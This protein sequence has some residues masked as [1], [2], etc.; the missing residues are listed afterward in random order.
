MD[1]HDVMLE[2][3]NYDDCSDFLEERP[4]ALLSV[5]Y[6]KS[7]VLVMLILSRRALKQLAIVSDDRG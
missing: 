6:E 2:V 4:A 5:Y 7:A 1:P 3:D